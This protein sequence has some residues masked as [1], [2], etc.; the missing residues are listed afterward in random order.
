MSRARLSGT[1]MLGERCLISGLDLALDPGWTC[2]LGAS[3]SGK[4][5]LLRLLA[6]LPVAARLAGSRHAPDR[7]GWM[8]QADLLQ[9]RFSA[10][11][12][13]RLMARLRGARL[14]RGQAEALLA[15]VGL[16][17][18]GG[19]AP[20]TLSGGERQ[21]VA[22]ARVLADAAP[23]VLLDEPFSALDAP[24]RLAMQALAHDTLAGRTVVMVTHDPVEALR[25]G[26]R[27][28]LLSGARL[29]ELPSLPGKKPLAPD[30]PGLLQA[31]AAL[32]AR[33]GA[34]L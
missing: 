25:L 7:I 29:A 33:M 23:L 31:A 15:S 3:G 5:T 22:L 16:S 19:A 34:T 13:V 24:T 28:L 1:V 30:D 21:R 14:S 18:R 4:S 17:G 26:D 2:L 27:V 6:G 12:N 10:L 11:A 32:V 9:P 8:A 20:E